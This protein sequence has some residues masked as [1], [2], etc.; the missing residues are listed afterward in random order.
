M[1]TSVVDAEIGVSLAD[2]VGRS[3]P[4][5]FSSSTIRADPAPPHRKALPSVLRTLMSSGDNPGTARTRW[6]IAAPPPHRPPFR[7]DDDGC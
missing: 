2:V 5:V 6:R 3:L 1:L 7:L 4:M